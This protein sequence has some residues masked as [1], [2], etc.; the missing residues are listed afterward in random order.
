MNMLATQYIRAMHLRFGHGQNIHWYELVLLPLAASIIYP[1]RVLRWLFPKA[2]SI[3]QLVL[4]ELAAI[5]LLV[6]GTVLLM[7]SFADF[8]WWVP[9]ALVLFCL[10]LRVVLSLL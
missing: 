4:F 8:V 7:R 1:D 6:V 2:A 5:G 9:L 10:V 3:F